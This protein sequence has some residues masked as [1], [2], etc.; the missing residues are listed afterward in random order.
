VHRKCFCDKKNWWDWA[1]VNSIGQK[2][3]RCEASHV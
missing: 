1:V 3:V 2:I